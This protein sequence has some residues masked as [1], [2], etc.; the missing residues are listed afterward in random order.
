[1]LSYNEIK[2]RKYIVIDGEP[3]EVVS[4][5]VFRKQQR[6]PVNQTKLKSL[7]NGK[8]RE[9][10]FHQSESVEEADIERKTITYLYAK[11]EERWFCEQG[12]RSKRFM[13]DASVI[14]DQEKFMKENSDVDAL[15]FNEEVIGVTLPIKVIYKVVEAPPN[16]KGNTA[17]GGNKPVVIETGATVTTPLFI[18][19]GDKIEVNTETGEYV[20]RA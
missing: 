20:S 15:V 16:I 3:F 4:S 11:N 18:E 2:P 6:K 9:I 13:L 19:A 14:A 17:Q 1:M 10:S 5:H 8:V 7:I 12:D